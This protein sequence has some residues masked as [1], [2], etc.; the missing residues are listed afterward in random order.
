MQNSFGDILWASVSNNALSS[1]AQLLKQ[2][3]FGVIGK[4]ESGM[5]NLFDSFVKIS[6]A[7]LRR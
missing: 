3:K 5:S 4:V 1:I 6:H 2:C 7:F